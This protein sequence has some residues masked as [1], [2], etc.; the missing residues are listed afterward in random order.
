MTA[1]P[2]ASPDR[3]EPRHHAALRSLTRALLA[4][5]ALLGGSYLYMRLTLPHPFYGTAVSRPYPAADITGTS[6]RGTPF[7]LSQTR[8]DITLLFFGFT[9][10]PSICPMTLR[11]LELA[12]L[13]LPPEQQREMQLVFV[14]LDPAR[15][16]P[17]KMREYTEFFSSRATGVVLD[18]AELARVTRAYNVS[19]SRED[20]PGGDY[21]INHTA[22]SYLIDRDGQVRLI[23]DYTQLPNTERVASDLKFF[24]QE[25][26]AG[27]PPQEARL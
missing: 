26:H 2:P 24:L 18:S 12:R 8:G 15:D 22:G 9:H 10:C 7:Q 6:H 21:Q 25:D 19:Y 4:V 13:N 16:T 17:E 20:L 3:G 14:T 1:P 11:H 27:H 5:A 23:F